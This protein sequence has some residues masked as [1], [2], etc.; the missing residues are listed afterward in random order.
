MKRLIALPFLCLLLFSCDAL[1]P[2]T[3]VSTDE[4]KLVSEWLL[5]NENETEHGL[6]TK[7]LS[8]I[9][10]KD[11]NKSTLNGFA[12]CN[13]FQGAYNALSGKIMIEEVAITKRACP[14]LDAENQYLS[15]LKKVNRYEIKGNNLYLYQD[16]LILLHFKKK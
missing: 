9:F 1:K 15:L 12:G 6:N 13:N 10:S 8:L 2:I 11:L 4:R 7:P 5:Q 3:R 14:Q 16:Q